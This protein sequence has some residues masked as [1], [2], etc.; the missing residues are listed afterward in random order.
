MNIMVTE[1]GKDIKKGMT[2]TLSS[3][4]SN[5]SHSFLHS[6]SLIQQTFHIPFIQLYN[7]YQLIL[8]I[9][10]KFLC[11]G[12][13]LSVS[14]VKIKTCQVNHYPKTITTDIFGVEEQSECGCRW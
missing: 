9:M 1:G 2:E 10:A 5:P 8:V 14:M 13:F 12:D 4:S 6:L 11:S 7:K 3:W